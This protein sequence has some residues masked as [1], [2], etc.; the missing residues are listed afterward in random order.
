VIDGNTGLL[1]EPGRPD[2]IAAA[3]ERLIAD[4]ALAA[5]LATAGRARVLS[6]FDLHQTTAELEA[7][8]RAAIDRGRSSP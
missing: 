6:A 5:R 2:E 4:P 8:F 3:I 1:V 7:V